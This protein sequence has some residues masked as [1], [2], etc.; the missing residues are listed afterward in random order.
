MDGETD[1][2]VV[3]SNSFS[4]N[5]PSHQSSPALQQTPSTEHAQNQQDLSSEHAQSSPL[6]SGETDLDA[7]VLDKQDST[8]LD[9]V[10]NTSVGGDGSEMSMGSDIDTAT[11]VGGKLNA[12]LFVVSILASFMYLIYPRNN[13]LI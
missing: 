11:V 12:I 13:K 2:D 7:V 4:S 8:D 10:M 1:L 5:S 3:L 6:A 9:E